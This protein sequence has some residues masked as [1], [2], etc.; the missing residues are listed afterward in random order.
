MDFPLF[1]DGPGGRRREINLGGLIT[2]TSQTSLLQ[3]AKARRMQRND[4]RKRQESATRI[5]SW[6]RGRKHAQ[7][8]RSELRRTF[9]DNITNITG[10]RCLVLIGKDEA[11]LGRWAEAILVDN[12]AHLIEAGSDPTWTISLRK[13]SVLLL[14]AV[15]DSP[16]SS[17]ADAQLR[18]IEAL[19]SPQSSSKLSSAQMELL[20]YLLNHGYYSLLGRAISRV[21][22]QSKSIPSLPTL[23]S[24]SVLPFTLLDPA[25]PQ[26]ML[27]VIHFFSGVLTVPLLPNRLP[28]LSLTFL[29]PRI[30]LQHLT[31]DI[32][33]RVLAFITS[34]D[35]RVQLLANL[36]AF[37]P[38]RYNALPAPAVATYLRLTAETMMVLP[39]HALEPP[40][41]NTP[42]SN[43]WAGD[44]EE[45]D[46]GESS[47]HVEVV[48]IF[49]APSRPLP[50][51]DSKTRMRLQTLPSPAHLN[52][53]VSVA[54]KHTG[55]TSR[56]ALVKWLQALSTIWPSRRDR[57]AG[58]VVAWSGGG[59][60]RE[61]YRGYVRRNPFGTAGN[62]AALTDPAHAAHWPPLLFLV[63]LYNQAL[64][65]MGDDEFFSSSPTT[66]SSATLA[67]STA[68]T[69]I[70]A[71][72]PLTLDE[73]ASFSKQ[74]L[75][76]VFV[77]YWREDQ[78][79]VSEA[80][81][82]GI[83]NLSL[84]NVRER[85]TKLL[86]AIH[87]RDSR[88]PFTPPDH[89]LM[90][91]QVDIGPFVDAAI[92]EES[93][94]SHDT[95]G[96]APRNLSKRQIALLSP[97]LGVL[98]NIPFAIPFDVRVSIFRSFVQND[99]AAR[100]Y[101]LRSRHAGF[102][103]PVRVTVRRGNIAQD[104][105]N[106]LG[107]VD[108]KGPIAITFIDQF[109]QEEAGIDGGGVFKEF[110]T[111]LCKEVF[112]TDRGL[113]LASKKNE[114]YP[115]PHSYATESGSLAWYR[116]IG[117]ILGKALYEGILVDVAFAGFFLAKWLG[118]QSFLDD[119]ASLDPEL[120]QGLIFL[121]H[122]TGNPEDLSLTFA[123]TSEEFDV[124][125]TIPLIPNGDQIPVTRENRLQYIYLISHYR[126]NKQIKRQSDAFFEGLS[127]MIDPKWLRM[128]NQQELQ[129]LLGGVNSP[130]DLDDLRTNTQYG[131]LFN[132]HESTIEMFWR[133]VNTF[134]QDQRRALLRFATS[135][136]RPPLLGFKELVPNFAVR[137]AG[138]DENRLPTASTCVNLLKLPRYTSERMLREKLLQ[139]IQSNAGFDLS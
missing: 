39:I 83:P 14:H 5:Q 86:Q 10:L 121:K 117:R 100:G 102:N 9:E 27:A 23:V 6:W 29:A 45:S 2:A 19:L 7:R 35:A 22:A 107:D 65:T 92:Y 34:D 53:L 24:L 41:R 70:T 126:L 16:L 115:N 132:D 59:L 138:S 37:A 15:S 96:T 137:D 17:A 104:G 40:E 28:L 20:S 79:N 74:L 123:V 110:L 52:S 82:P 57:I 111:E 98:N 105:F 36:T 133:V 81:V 118:K 77:L 84:E 1:G 131:G 125:R 93:Q 30:P 113:W 38:P 129:I 95:T 71:R 87:A 94:M 135:C 116:F 69:T 49:T 124:T 31:V 13:V 109:G 51:L 72:N 63:D 4:L 91:S 66:L 106:R 67:A 54:Y 42:R 3:D 80:T 44:D 62:V 56:E 136:S 26:F 85:M 58:V 21:P 61:V 75:S 108:L 50:T 60:V 114:L 8:V 11:L 47:T 99:A 33:P 12:A 32:V 130:I 97:R 120:Y 139:A 134:N 128:F 48:S 103:P 43:A 64:L 89:W 68:T 119:L 76:I 78:T 88:R 73:I 46:E 127:E 101:N 122:Y 90:T 55:N 18:V 25:S 112:D